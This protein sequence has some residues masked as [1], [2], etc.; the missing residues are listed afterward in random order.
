MSHFARLKKN[1]TT[2]EL[3]K[4]L[5]SVGFSQN[6]LFWW[7]TYQ[8]KKRLMTQACI[9]MDGGDFLRLWGDKF[10]KRTAKRKYNQ[11]AAYMGYEVAELLR[12]YGLKIVCF[13]HLKGKKSPYVCYVET[14][15]V[16]DKTYPHI[17]EE[18]DAEARGLMLKYLYDRK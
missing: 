4:R 3:S 7:K 17:L 16:E 13:P 18:T 14:D 9:K 5:A 12:P 1:I 11:Y 15:G 6:S 8:T 2:L 10:P